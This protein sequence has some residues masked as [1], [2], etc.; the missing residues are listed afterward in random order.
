MCFNN[1]RVLVTE[2]SRLF[3]RDSNIVHN[4]NMDTRKEKCVTQKAHILTG[5]KASYWLEYRRAI[6]L[7]IL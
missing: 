1:K 2:T 7:E 4:S 5:K 6:T 3:V